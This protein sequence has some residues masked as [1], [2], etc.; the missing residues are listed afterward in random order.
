[1]PK[2]S[3]ILSDDDKGSRIVYVIPQYERDVFNST[4]LFRSIKELYPEYNLYVATKKEYFSIL[5]GNP[6][7]H[8]VIEYSPQ[9]D[10]IFWLEGRGS[11]D[12]FFEIA[13]IPY[14]NTQKIV[15]FTHNGKDKIAYKD[16][17]Y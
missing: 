14:I 7:V 17:K 10:N 12:G 9:M 6:H 11:Y 16:L 5:D 13:F 2:I 3:D 8:K 1:M 4:G 15:T